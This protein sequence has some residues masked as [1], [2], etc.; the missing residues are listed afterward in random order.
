MNFSGKRYSR[1]T[2]ESLLDSSELETYV[3]DCSDRFGSYGTVG[4]CI[5]DSREPR[6][7]DLLF[8]CRVQSRRVEH[9]FVS[10]VL[11]RYRNR[12]RNGLFADFK[13]TERNA[14]SGK[15]FDELGFAQKGNNEGVIDLY[16]SFESSILD[17]E[18]IAVEEKLDAVDRNIV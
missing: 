16:F 2:I 10:Y 6:M 5:V 18:V 1:E 14:Q 9:A 7:L 17:E 13:K 12:G 4:F 11:K 15:V 8:S 3:I